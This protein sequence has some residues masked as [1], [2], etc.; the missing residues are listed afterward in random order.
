MEEDLLE[1]AEAQV[2]E[3]VKED[4]IVRLQALC[5]CVP[6]QLLGAATVPSKQHE[7]QH[8]LMV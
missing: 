4:V 5:Q 8:P 3:E 1:E 2:T 7:G 6:M